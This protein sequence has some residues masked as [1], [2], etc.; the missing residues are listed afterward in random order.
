MA[1]AYIEQRM[2]IICDNGCFNHE[3]DSNIGG[4]INAN[5]SNCIVHLTEVCT[6]DDRA[7]WD[8]ICKVTLEKLNRKARETLWPVSTIDKR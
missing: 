7:I 8:D 6:C 2:H 3:L 5:L 1:I 4:T